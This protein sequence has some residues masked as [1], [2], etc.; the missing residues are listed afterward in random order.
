MTPLKKYEKY[1][2]FP[3]KL[4]IQMLLVL[5]TTCQVVLIVNQS[6]T[7]AYSQYTLFNML[8]LNRQVTGSSSPITNSY[9]LFG[10]TSLTNYIQVTVDRY[11]DI[12]SQT[13]SNFDYHY[14]SDGSKKPPRLLVDYFDNTK[15][16]NDGDLFEYQLLTNDLGPFSQPDTKNYLDNVKAFY[17]TFELIHNLD[18]YINLASDCYE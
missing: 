16:I 13:I 4:I 17:I 10:L 11:Y 6:T 7:Y 1:G 5:F 2:R 14:R 18:S 3:Y 12:N 8:F 9:I 15:A